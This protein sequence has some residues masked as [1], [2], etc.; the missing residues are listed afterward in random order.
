ME[1]LFNIES[2]IYS[3][4]ETYEKKFAFLANKILNYLILE[5]NNRDYIIQELEFY[6]Y[7]DTHP[8]TYTHKHPYQKL[9]GH[10]YFHKQGTSDTYKSGTFKGLD[11]IFT[12]NTKDAFGGILI[13]SISNLETHIIGPCNVVDHILTQNKANTIPE[14]ITNSIPTNS[15]FTKSGLYIKLSKEIRSN[16]ICYGPRVGL[17]FKYPI[18][19]NKN[20]RFLTNIK[21]NDK[22]RGTIIIVLYQLGIPISEI[23]NITNVKKSIIEKYIL[24]YNT[25]TIT[26]EQLQLM[27]NIPSLAIVLQSIISNTQKLIPHTKILPKKITLKIITLNSDN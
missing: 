1:E 3:E 25:C 20:Y 26:L 24:T 17:S 23:I 22:Y 19:A 14:L 10:W 8:D 9:F 6:L 7:S 5:I 12:D 18:W 13:R 21:T 11:I 27:K 15:C 16:S 2:K 4:Y